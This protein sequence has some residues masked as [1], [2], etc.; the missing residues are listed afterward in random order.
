MAG[1]HSSPSFGVEV[2]L[3]CIRPGEAVGRSS[4]LPSRAL[5][6]LAEKRRSV[7][8]EGREGRFFTG[9]LAYCEM[10]RL[11][12]VASWPAWD[13]PAL[14]RQE[15]AALELGAEGFRLLGLP[16]RQT[17]VLCLPDDL[18]G[19][20]AARRRPIAR[21]RD[22]SPRSHSMGTHFNVHLEGFPDAWRGFIPFAAALLPEITGPGGFVRERPDGR[23]R[24]LRDPR[25]AHVT[26]LAY[27]RAH[28]PGRPIVKVTEERHR[29][30]IVSAGHT[31]ARADREIRYGL[32]MLLAVAAARREDVPALHLRPVEAI[33]AR[34]RQRLFCHR[35]GRLSRCTRLDL[36]E[37]LLETCLAP[38]AASPEGVRL[39]AAP[40]LDRIRAAIAACRTEEPRGVAARVPLGWAIKLQCFERELEARGSR[41]WTEERRRAPEPPSGIDERLAVMS[42]LEG[43]LLDDSVRRHLLAGVEGRPWRY[44]EAYGFDPEV[45]ACARE[46]RAVPGAAAP[47]SVMQDLIDGWPREDGR[48]P[49]MG[50]WRDLYVTGGERAVTRSIPLGSLQ[51]TS[52]EGV[53]G[54]VRLY[55]RAEP[56]G[57]R[58]G[59]PFSELRAL[60]EAA[61]RLRGERIRPPWEGGAEREGLPP[62]TGDSSG[63]GPPPGEEP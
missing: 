38:V 52:R 24:F 19:T 7:P 57:P 61:L 2:E 34:P 58:R 12:E 30:Q 48:L 35:G 45:Q 46:D 17:A 51:W 44:E 60:R 50:T 15:E 21:S 16:A 1:D 49:L 10:S 18:A 41:L 62:L 31:L 59:S 8:F 42:V 40:A 13:L 27:R 11:L 33:H 37:E 26:R 47:A 29:L 56:V 20:P 32:L 14:L 22:P 54:L 4:P 43:N 5:A 23:L 9:G 6:A 36:L 3:V 53:R 28:E 25:S 63:R 39:R 55:S